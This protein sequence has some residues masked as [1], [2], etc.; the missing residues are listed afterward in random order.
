MEKRISREEIREALCRRHT[1]RV[2]EKLEQAR[3]AIAGL[4][5]L[6]S[7]IAVNLA[8][9]GVG[10]LHLVDFDRVDLTNLNRQQYRLCHLGQ[11]KT[12]ALRK[13]LLEINPWLDIM[14]DCVKVT[15]ENLRELF[16][17]DPMI[18]EAFDVPECKAMLVNGILEYFPDKILV[19]ASGMAGYGDSNQI[20]TRKITSHFYLCGDEKTDVDAAGGLMAPRVAICAGHQANLILQLILQGEIWKET[21]KS[22]IIDTVN[23]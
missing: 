23:V 18:C 7:S 22:A 1:R 5:G 12:E 3:V 2:Q 17:K 11:F 13:E 14:V 19:A 8:R 21:S 10:H 16:A 4:G 6:G 20:R 15:E 9:A